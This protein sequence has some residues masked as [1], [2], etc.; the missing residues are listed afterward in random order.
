MIKKERK[1]KR[2]KEKKEEREKERKINN[3]EI[4]WTMKKINE[5][6]DEQ[7]MEKER[8]KKEKVIC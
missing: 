5:L 2:S 1:Q 6:N 7:K 3:E 4:N 8:N